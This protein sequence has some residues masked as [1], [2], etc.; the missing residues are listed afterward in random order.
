MFVNFIKFVDIENN[1]CKNLKINETLFDFNQA[2]L[3][4]F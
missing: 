2:L 1:N 4:I 3:V